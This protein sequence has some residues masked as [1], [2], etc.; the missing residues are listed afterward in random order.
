SDQTGGV[1]LSAAYKATG[2]RIEAARTIGGV[3]LRYVAHHCVQ[4]N[5][6]AQRIF[7][8]PGATKA[9]IVRVAKGGTYRQ[10][11]NILSDKSLSARDRGERLKDFELARGFSANPRAIGLSVAIN[12]IALF[13]AVSN[14][15]SD[16]FATALAVMVGVGALGQA[17]LKHDEYRYVKARVVVDK[18]DVEFERKVKFQRSAGAAVAGLALAL[19]IWTYHK[20][21][22]KGPTPRS[23]AVAGVSSSSA[24]FMS[25][26][27]SFAKVATRLAS[28]LGIV[29]NVI[30]IAVIIA[31]IV[32]A[33]TSRS[34]K[35]LL[36]SYL[37]HL[38]APLESEDEDERSW[39]SWKTGD[40]LEELRNAIDDAGDAL[41]SF[42]PIVGSR[43]STPWSGVPTY[44]KAKKLGFGRNEICALFDVDPVAVAPLF[45]GADGQEDGA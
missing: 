29:G 6:P 37:D 32:D 43:D 41:D 18:Y 27:L 26:A 36:E 19:S 14:D 4:H 2:S 30:G 42:K 8:A 35:T 31:S 1:L 34:P 44:W 39:V 33:I 3:F 21:K 9:D 7:V 20:D 11:M 24:S 12:A 16:P 45:V 13:G 22:N 28:I 17:A 25:S 10:V 40:L 23:L 38:E 15:D 5:S